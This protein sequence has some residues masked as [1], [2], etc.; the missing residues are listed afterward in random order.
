M[1]LAY[2]VHRWRDWFSV[3]TREDGFGLRRWVF[4]AATRMAVTGALLTLVFAAFMPVANVFS[5]NSIVLSHDT[6]SVNNQEDQAEG[7]G[8]SVGSPKRSRSPTRTRPNRP[9]C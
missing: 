8:S 6:G 2:E 1:N 5:V 4:L 3:P 7:P 9:R